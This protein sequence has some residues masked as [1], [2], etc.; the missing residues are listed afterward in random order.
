M[1]ERASVSAVETNL[2]GAIT[3]GFGDVR[4]VS[5]SYDSERVLFSMRTPID[6]DADIEDQPTWNIWEYNRST[7]VLRRVMPDD[8]T[9]EEGQDIAPYFLPDGRIL[10][11]ST[12]QNQSVAKLLDQGKPQYAAQDESDNEPAFVLH[13]MNDDGTGIEQISFN[14]SHDLWPSLATALWCRQPRQRHWRCRGA[15]SETA[16]TA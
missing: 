15:V 2:T 13:V 14:Q 7:G 6:P 3:N 11:S 1:R 10:F 8:I 5:V 9:A 4:D 16:G 12:R